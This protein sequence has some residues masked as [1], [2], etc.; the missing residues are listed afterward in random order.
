MLEYVEEGECGTAEEQ[1]NCADT[2]C[3]LWVDLDSRAVPTQTDDGLELNPADT[4]W[5]FSIDD[6]VVER[7]VFLQPARIFNTYVVARND[8]GLVIYDNAL[9]QAVNGQCMIGI[10]AEYHKNYKAL[11]NGWPR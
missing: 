11:F 6:Q 2:V 8:E 1:D 3:S 9:V 7:T 5:L 4:F 10:T